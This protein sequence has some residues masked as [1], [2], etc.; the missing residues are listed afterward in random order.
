[1]K[2]IPFLSAC[3]LMFMLAA[4][5]TFDKNAYRAVSTTTTTVEA[6]R[7]SWVA[8]VTQQRVLT[9]DAAQRQDLEMKVAKVGVAYG[10]YQSAMRAAKL[11][12]DAYHLAPTNQAP[13]LTALGALSAASGELVGLINSFTSTSTK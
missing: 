8:Y 7:K 13:V 12:V 11:A 3:A 9:P 10:Q 5:A 2:H 6:A 4:C 1:M